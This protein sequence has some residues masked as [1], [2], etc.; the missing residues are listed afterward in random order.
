M[1]KLLPVVADFLQKSGLRKLSYAFYV[2]GIVAL[3]TFQQKISETAFT[4]VSTWLL[5]GVFASNSFEHF[6]RTKGEKLNAPTVKID[7]ATA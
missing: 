6:V 5:V 4:E 1:T 3:L 2:E 7:S